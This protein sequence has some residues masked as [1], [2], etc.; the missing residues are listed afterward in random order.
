MKKPAHWTQPIT[1]T[2]IPAD[3]RART[4]A[5]KTASRKVRNEGRHLAALERAAETKHAYEATAAK[6]QQAQPATAE[7][8]E[9]AEAVRP[10]AN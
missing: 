2:H 7:R 5:G 9:T 4:A 1:R 8:S 10:Q 6:S 3:D